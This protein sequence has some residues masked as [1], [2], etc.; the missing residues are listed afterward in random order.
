MVEKP[1][2]LTLEAAWGRNGYFFADD[3]TKLQLPNFRLRTKSGESTY[4]PS[5]GRINCAIVPHDSFPL[6]VLLRQFTALI[7]H[8]F[9]IYVLFVR[10]DS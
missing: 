8:C 9:L 7:T 10:F 2:G 3:G 4:M 1:E 5:S 6:P